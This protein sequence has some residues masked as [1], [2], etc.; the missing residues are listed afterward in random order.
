MSHITHAFPFRQKRMAGE[1]KINPLGRLN[2]SVEKELE[3]KSLIML[4][5]LGGQSVRWGKK[6]EEVVVL[7]LLFFF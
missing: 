7:L 2:L 4:V 6:I 5:Y 3:C 1:E